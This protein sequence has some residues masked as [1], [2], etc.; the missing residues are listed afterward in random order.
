V[1]GATTVAGPA[2]ADSAGST[3]STP[4]GGSQGV[5]PLGDLL[6]PAPE[7]RPGRVGGTALASAASYSLQPKNCPRGTQ[8]ITADLNR[9]FDR[10]TGTVQLDEAAPA[11]TRARFTATADGEVLQQAELSPTEGATF[12]LEVK[13]RDSLVFTL[14]TAGQGSCESDGYL[15]FVTS[16]L[17][18][19]SQP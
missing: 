10:V 2:A 19:P 13:A 17:A 7:Y 3:G 18:Y 8:Q 12:D 9:S 15:A 16:A 5:Q 14:E 11:T 4:S 1:S 6:T